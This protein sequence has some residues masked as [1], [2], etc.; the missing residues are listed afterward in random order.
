M[1]PDEL[2]AEIVRSL[3]NG[4]TIE[5]SHGLLIVDLHP[6]TWVDALTHARDTL[7]CTFFD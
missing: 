6:K 5:I 1:T 3:G 7:G 4:A 2:G